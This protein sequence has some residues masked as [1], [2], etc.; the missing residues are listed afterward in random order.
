[1]ARLARG[2]AQ[3]RDR[4]RSRQ[5]S[6]IVRIA[7]P[8]ARWALDKESIVNW[9]LRF[10]NERGVA[11]ALAYVE[12]DYV[13]EAPAV[14]RYTAELA[15]A[16]REAQRDLGAAR[17]VRQP[18][19]VNY[20]A[21]ALFVGAS[22]TIQRLEALVGVRENFLF[23]ARHYLRA[24][25]EF[26][27]LALLDKA[28]LYLRPAVEGAAF[29]EPLERQP[30]AAGLLHFNLHIFRTDELRMREAVLRAHLARTPEDIARAG[31]LLQSI[32]RP[33]YRRLAETA[34]SGG[35]DFCDISDGWGGAEELREAC[36][37][38]D[39]MQDRVVNYWISRAVLAQVAPSGEGREDELVMRLLQLEQLPD[40]GRCCYSDAVG[41]LRRLHLMRADR[42]RR[43]FA[44]AA[45]RGDPFEAR[46]RW[47]E[48]L[49][50]LAKA[51]RLA[52]AAEGPARFRRIAQAW[53]DLWALGAEVRPRPGETMPPLTDFAG[54]PA[55]RGLSAPA[56]GRPRP[57]RHGRALKAV[58]PARWTAPPS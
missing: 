4:A 48:A 34:F 27:S 58:V 44:E 49:D 7:D 51:E 36:G 26:G 52:P 38:D 50:E 53:L 56:A 37:A 47:H 42:Q 35:D 54:A 15:R 13:R 46:E 43:A 8:C 22:R 18:D 33:L 57:N 14:E 17:D 23:L 29:L 2:C 6:A 25:E 28:A 39:E 11:A 21:Q 9:H 55:L 20:S 41:D 30:A 19:G 24:A 3:D 1:M 12:R 10:G 5:L 16:W 31:A 40:H 45:A 32:E